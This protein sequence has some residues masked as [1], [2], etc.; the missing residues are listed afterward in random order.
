[1]TTSALFNQEGGS[2]INSIS[3]NQLHLLFFFVS[4]YLIALGQGMYKP[5]I[6]AF[7]ADQFNEQDPQELCARSSY[8][9]WWFFSIFAGPLAALVV[10][11]YIQD[12]VSWAIGFGIPCIAMAGSLTIFMLGTKKYRYNIKTTE[13][14]A[15]SRVSHVF[16]KA[17]KNYRV[18]Q[19]S[20]ASEERNDK[21]P[22]LYTQQFK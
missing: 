10:L 5:C 12:N 17:A 3:P 16:L 18:I 8:F 2:S 9:N 13:K 22:Q 1:M 14:C 4:L 11:N 21:V 6:V 20:S 7:G 15:I 19:S